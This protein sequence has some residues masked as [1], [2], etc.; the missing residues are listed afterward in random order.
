MTIQTLMNRVAQMDFNN[1]QGAC[2]VGEREGR[3]FSEMVKSK[4]W[5]LA[6]G[7]GRSVDVNALQ[8]KAIGSS[9]IVQLSRSMT[10]NLF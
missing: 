1:Y 5:L 10:I 6:H 8:P 2:G 7:I 9:L 4:N 3:I